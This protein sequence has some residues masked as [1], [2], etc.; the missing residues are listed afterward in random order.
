MRTNLKKTEFS[1]MATT[2][3]LMIRVTLNDVQPVV[4]RTLNVPNSKDLLALAAGTFLSMGWEADAPFHFILPNGGKVVDPQQW[5]DLDDDR[6]VEMAPANASGQ[7][8]KAYFSNGP[9]KL[10][11]ETEVPWTLELTLDALGTER[12]ADEGIYVE[13]GAYAGPP[14]WCGGKEGYRF[15]CET[16]AN[17]DSPDYPAVVENLYEPFNPSFFSV[18]YTN[19]VLGVNAKHVE[20]AYCTEDED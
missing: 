2:H 8:L 19:D 18:G 12:N 5:M 17:P 13:F 20:E 1:T 11:Y 4:W 6:K 9:M 15:L 10:V 3:S 16:L 14:Q 7:D